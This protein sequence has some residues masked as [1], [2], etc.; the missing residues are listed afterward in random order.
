[1]PD[2]YEQKMCCIAIRRWL[3]KTDKQVFAKQN[4]SGRMLTPPGISARLNRCQDQLA[5][6]QVEIRGP[7]CNKT[8]KE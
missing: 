6:V 3:L 5:R 2:A 7:N 4:E 8:G 1:M